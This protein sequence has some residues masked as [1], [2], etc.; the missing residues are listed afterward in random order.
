MQIIYPNSDQRSSIQTFEILSRKL[1]A[2]GDNN[3]M[4]NYLM[5]VEKIFGKAFECKN[6][7]SNVYFSNEKISYR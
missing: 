5:I 2:F 4:A 1:E 3:K 7:N 6:I